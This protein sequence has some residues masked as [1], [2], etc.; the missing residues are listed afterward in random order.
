MEPL[1]IAFEMS[2]ELM[3][4]ALREGHLAAGREHFRPR[5]LLIVAASA[6]IFVRAVLLHSHWLWWTAAFPPA[7][8]ALLLL[9]WAVAWLRLPA[10]AKRRLARLPHRHVR[11]AIGPQTFLLE[12]AAERLETPLSELHSLQRLPSVWVIRL[13]GG[14]RIPVPLEALSVE[15]LAALRAAL[16]A[17]TPA[18]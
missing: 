9:Y 13:R 7:A 8:F 14:A 3:A 4:R 16:P 12:T 18:N 5:N 15:A 10:L 2:D 6:A 1:T 11:I 17:S